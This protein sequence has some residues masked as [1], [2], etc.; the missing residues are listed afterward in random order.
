MNNEGFE[1]LP[2]KSISKVLC[3]SP[4]HTPEFIFSFPPAVLRPNK[5]NISKEK[6]E[7][8]LLG[9]RWDCLTSDALF[10]T[11]NEFFSSSLYLNIISFPGPLAGSLLF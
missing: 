7:F 4:W 5:E 9:F 8:I 2:L 11:L 6:P 3:T 10:F 1:T